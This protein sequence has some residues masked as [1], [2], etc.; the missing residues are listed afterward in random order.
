[1]A[2]EAAK[3]GISVLELFVNAM[4]LVFQKYVI[5]KNSNILKRQTGVKRFMD[6]HNVRMSPLVIVDQFLRLTGDED[7]GMF[8]LKL[9]GRKREPL[10]P[11]RGY[12]RLR[13]L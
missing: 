4:I 6:S 5:G 10:D 13:A 8:S 9:N 11:V 7:R 1:M 2:Y 12:A 3:Q